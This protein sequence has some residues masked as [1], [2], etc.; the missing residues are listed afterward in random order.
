[1]SGEF[2]N[3][4]FTFSYDSANVEH[5]IYVNEYLWQILEGKN[6][7]ATMTSILDLHGL[8]FKYLRQGDIVNF[9]KEFVKTMDHHYPQRAHKTLIINAPKW[10]NLLYKIVSPLLRESTK[11]K[12]EIFTRGKRQDKVLKSLLGNGNN[13]EKL[14]PASFF[15]KK[16]DQKPKKDDRNQMMMKRNRRGMHTEVEEE[17]VDESPEGNHD[18]KDASAS[19]ADGDEIQND[20]N[21]GAVEEGAPILPSKFETELREFVRTSRLNV[22]LHFLNAKETKHTM[23]HVLIFVSV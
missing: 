1:M 14:F 17:V 15:T 7:L 4:S 13:A 5:Y 23:S 16:K 22:S 6:A 10:F 20:D 3:I 2:S 19:V 8:N 18:T 21:D 11:A 9:M 12:I